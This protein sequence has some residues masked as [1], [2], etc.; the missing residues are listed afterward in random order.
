MEPTEPRVSVNIRNDLIELQFLLDFPISRYPE[1]LKDF[2][3]KK[4]NPLDQLLGRIMSKSKGQTRGF[5]AGTIF[6]RTN[7]QTITAFLNY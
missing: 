7:Q 6:G 5:K 3:V 2:N 1:D 4:S